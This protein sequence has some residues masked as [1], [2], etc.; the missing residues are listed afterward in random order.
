MTPDLTPYL[1]LFQGETSTRPV[2]F[3][4]FIRQ[5]DL[6]LIT[7]DRG[8]G[9]S[10]AAVEFI[11]TLFLPEHQLIEDPLTGSVS[12]DKTRPIPHNAGAFAGA[13]TASQGLWDGRC[14]VILDAENDVAEW[15][16]LYQET[17]R[18]RSIMPDSLTA[19]ACAE[20]IRWRDAHDMPFND[21]AR[22]PHWVND[23]LIPELKALNCGAL[24]IDSTHKC[25]T[26]D[27]NQ[28]EWVANGLGYL[29]YACRANDMTI[30]SITHTSRD[31]ANKSDDA[32]LLPSFSSQQEKEA[33]TILGLVRMKS[34]N[35][36]KVKLVKRRYAK[37]N[38]EDTW[39]KV[40][41]SPNIRGLLPRCLQSLARRAAH[42]VREV[43]A[44]HQSRG[45]LPTRH[46]PGCPLRAVPHP[47]WQPDPQQEVPRR[48]VHPAGPGRVPGRQW[49][50]VR[51]LQ[52]PPNQPGPGSQR[53][54]PCPLP[55]TQEKK[56]LN[57]PTHPC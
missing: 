51:P 36:L 21:L 44:P 42:Q 22:F 2:L 11:A 37:W 31:H 15:L 26:R 24:F 25:W 5:G 43:P 27:L 46:A 54:H 53:H 19:R 29:K 45:H 30:F 56:D 13:L 9:K 38:P 32:K 50:E 12:F 34:D 28:P 55:L 48:R 8:T 41:M 20:F 39:L 4:P 1:T 14:A 23:I 33:D 52:V 7:G 16:M 10:T 57:P 47:A 40:M 17:L 35:M 6:V 18:S 49:Q 3:S